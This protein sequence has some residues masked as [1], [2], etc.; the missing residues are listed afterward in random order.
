MRHRKS[1]A[2]S[3]DGGRLEAT[4]CAASSGDTSRE[5]C[6]RRAVLARG[7]HALQH[8]QQAVGLAGHE[9]AAE[10]DQPLARGGGGVRLAAAGRR[11]AGR[12]ALAIGQIDLRPGLHAHLAGQ[13]A[14]AHAATCPP[15]ASCQCGVNA[16]AT[17]AR[18]CRPSSGRTATLGS[19]SSVA[20]SRRCSSLRL[21]LE[22]GLQRRSPRAQ[23][24][25]RLL[26]AVDVAGWSPGCGPTP[27]AAARGAAALAAQERPQHRGADRDGGLQLGAAGLLAL[28][29]DG[30]L[31]PADALLERGGLRRVARAQL[32]RPR[33][34]AARA[35]AW[36]SRRRNAASSSSARD[37]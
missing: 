34:R 13:L 33:R 36:A 28:A 37:D 16:S 27:R 17:S 32:G 25:H 7:V 29:V 26:G 5:Q 31:G 24:G 15:A 12:P 30:G 23:G 4:R 18:R 11:P 6:V 35:P 10:H 19:S 2:S 21:G 3:L 14:H 1:C 9:L 8:E 20:G 22:L